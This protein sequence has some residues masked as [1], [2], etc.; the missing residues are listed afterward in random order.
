MLSIFNEG[1]FLF[2]VNNIAI[3]YV[4]LVGTI[5]IEVYMFCCEGGRTSPSN[6]ICLSIFT[7]CEAYIVSFISSITGKE[8]GNSV[9]LLAGIYTLG[10]LTIT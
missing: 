1:F 4:A 8:S 6:Y 7:L 3:F 10:T 2:Q 5:V 9:V